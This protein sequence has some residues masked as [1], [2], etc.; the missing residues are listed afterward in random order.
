MTQTH[1][2]VSARDTLTQD[3]AA[4][5]ARRVADVSYAL[6]LDLRA[7]QDTYDGRATI[8][9]SL[10][11]RSEPLFLD[12]TGAV[13]SLTVNGRVVPADQRS[14]RLWLSADHLAQLVAGDGFGHGR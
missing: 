9:F 6:D 5:R 11:D 7:G 3:Q 2:S 14:H 4:A 1:D 13:T 8:R 10:R 12:F